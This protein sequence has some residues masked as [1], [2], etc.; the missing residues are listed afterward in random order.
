MCGGSPN[1]FVPS[2]VP[3][4]LGN[5]TTG[6][7]AVANYGTS[8]GW[9]GT[10]GPLM[11]VI[12]WAVIIYAIVVLVRHFTNQNSARTGGSENSAMLL[13]ILKERYASGEINGEEYQKKKKELEI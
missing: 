1:G 9:M 2:G 3:S 6:T 11:M 12:L 7:S 13:T 4:A 10:F 8:I 5:G